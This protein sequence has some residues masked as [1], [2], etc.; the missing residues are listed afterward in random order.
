MFNGETTDDLVHE[1]YTWGPALVQ[2]IRSRFPASALSPLLKSKMVARQKFTGFQVYVLSGVGLRPY[3][4]SV[5]YNYVP[6]KKVVLG[7]LIVRA[8]ARQYTKDG[9]DVELYDGYAKRGRDNILLARC[10][11]ELTVVIGRASLTMKATRVIASAL[12]EV[13]P[14]IVAI[15]AVVLQDDLDPLMANGKMASDIPLQVIQVPMTR[16][17]KE[18]FEGHSPVETVS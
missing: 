8:M 14:E 17:T 9:Y 18:S 16:I 2:D 5:R 15:H 6:A 10:N 3:G 12:R 11:G 4:Y 7:A 13:L 1:L